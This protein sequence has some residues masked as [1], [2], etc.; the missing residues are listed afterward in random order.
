MNNLMGA[1]ALGFSLTLA[2]APITVLAQD[3]QKNSEEAFLSDYSGLKPAT[4]NS[5]DKM[6]IAGLRPE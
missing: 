5:F 6:Y 1:T 2:F 4:D 3:A